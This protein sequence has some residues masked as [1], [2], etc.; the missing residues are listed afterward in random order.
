MNKV[1][2]IKDIKK[3]TDNKFLNM[4]DIVYETPTGK[5]RNYYMVSRRDA[6]DL[7]CVTG[8]HDKADAVAVIPQYQNGDIILLKQY[9]P[10]IN[11][12]IY[13][14]PAGLVDEGET[15]IQAAMRELK[16]ETGLESIFM[17]TFLRPCYS[18]CGMSDESVSIF[19]ATVKGE[20]SLDF[21]EENED[22]EIIILKEADI[23][24]FLK[25][26]TVAIRTALIL[27]YLAI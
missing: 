7:S 2:K 15:E 6:K 16:E 4:Y 11:D 18:S 1:N 8:R 22:I 27:K 10:V 5:D 20:I 19:R 25:E 23:N 14:F 13:E 3:I 12:Y 21:K 9:R 26:H 24:K 17:S